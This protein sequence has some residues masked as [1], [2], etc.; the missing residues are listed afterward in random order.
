MSKIKTVEL[1]DEAM[2]ELELEE[3]F[4]DADFSD[5][6]PAPR[7]AAGN[8]A[9][10]ADADDGDFD[11]VFDEFDRNIKEAASAFSER[12]PEAQAEAP[13]VAADEA[14]GVFDEELAEF[15]W[16]SDI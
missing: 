5:E 4:R 16:E 11:F 6:P 13:V 12:Q 15:D 10:A 3:A 8:A 14:P 1:S 2:I 7:T 9:A